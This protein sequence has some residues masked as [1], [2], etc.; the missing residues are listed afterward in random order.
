MEYRRSLPTAYT[1]II[2]VFAVL[3]MS[4]CGK[5]DRDA[6]RE[7]DQRE[8]DR[9]MRIAV[10]SGRVHQLEETLDLLER[11]VDI[12]RNRIQ[13]ARGDLEAIKGGLKAYARNPFPVP[14]V[15]SATAAAI[16]K[17]YRDDKIK[18]DVERKKAEKST[19]SFLLLL[20]FIAFVVV[21][22]GKMWKDR[23]VENGKD[24]I[25]EVGGESPGGSYTYP[26]SPPGSSPETLASGEEADSEKDPEPPLG[27]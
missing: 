14:E 8:K 9:V 6:S 13:A 11:D 2:T 19:L 23:R 17:N 16:L 7:R 27:E 12:Q 21:W 10:F 18:H 15:T 4:G 25:G 1:W 22:F 3:L 5:S 26:A 24:T 20:A